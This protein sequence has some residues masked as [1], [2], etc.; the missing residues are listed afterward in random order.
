M[1]LMNKIKGIMEENKISADDTFLSYPTGISMFDYRVGFYEPL[2]KE[3]NT[4]IEGGK[5]F[6]VIGRSGSGKTTFAIQTATNIVNKYEN[7][8]VMH[9]DFE[10]ATNASR[11]MNLSG[12][13]VDT[14]NQKYVLAKKGISS[15]S[16]Y[17][18]AKGI[19]KTKM[20]DYDNLKVDTGR[21]DHNGE[22]IYE[23]P[24]TVLI[25]DS[26]AS[27]FSSNIN[28]ESE[29]GGQMDVTQQAKQNN[30]LIK[31][32]SGSSALRNA[33]IIIIAVNHITQ[34]I[35]INPMMKTSAPINY[36]KQDESIP[37]KRAYCL[38]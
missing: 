7:G 31:R 2:S 1:S 33:N 38:A 8:M 16:V 20:D 18:L 14:Y 34:K 6:T 11:V 10:D 3:I 21:K 23:L 32:L 4:G 17:Q 13:D 24:P 15:D 27:M 5:L 30:Q 22:T 19:E 9:L 36:L 28:E 37:G 35:D 26:V 25:I 12:W 29:M